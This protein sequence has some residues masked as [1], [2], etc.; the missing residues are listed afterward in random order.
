MN[1]VKFKDLA[2]PNQD[3]FNTKLRGKY[4]YLLNMQ[5]AVS[6]ESVDY[7]QYVKYE[8]DF[9]TFL[10]QGIPYVDITS[11]EYASCVDIEETEKAN[12]IAPFVYFN[13]L[14]VNSELSIENIKEFR[15]WLTKSLLQFDTKPD[16]TQAY[17]LFNKQLTQALQ[18]YQLNKNTEFTS[19]LSDIDKYFVEKNQKPTSSCECS[20]SFST[21]LNEV[22]ASS[23]LSSSEKYHTMQRE[24][25]INGLSKV[26]LWLNFSI[27]FLQD[28]KKY[29]SEYVKTQMYKSVGTKI[30]H[31]QRGG[32]LNLQ[33]SCS[34]NTNF[35]NVKILFTD[36]EQILDM[37]IQFK[38][39]FPTKT[40]IDCELLVNYNKIYVTLYN[41]FTSVF[42]YL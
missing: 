29:L 17:M 40:D 3:F 32:L 39:Q 18:Y 23:C 12:S 2:V 19:L 27:E 33:T 16:G 10:A 31:S 20:T 42:D 15:A 21:T 6:F 14:H 35:D 13:T 22:N 36:L 1:I 25:V 34:N 37:Y 7:V 24:I 38:T 5:Y 4:A 8:R 9:S 41:W 11:V 30:V 28:F 26:E